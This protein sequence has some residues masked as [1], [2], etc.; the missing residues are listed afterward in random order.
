[1]AGDPLEPYRE[2]VRRH[3]ASFEGMLWRSPEMQVARFRILME[4]VAA[5]LGEDGTGGRSRSVGDVLAGAVVADIGCGMADLRGWLGEGGLG[6]A[7]Y[8]GVDGVEDLVASASAR[9]EREGWSD[10]SL[11]VSDFGRDEDLF[12]RLVLERGARVFVFSGS[13]N[14]FEQ[15]AALEIVG[16]AFAAVGS[17]GDGVRRGV[18]LNFLSS[19]WFGSVASPDD[20]ARRFDP[21]EVVGFGLGL[22]PRVLMRHDYLDGRDATVGLFTS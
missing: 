7:G 9:A 2:A 10:A 21:V 22:T 20:P 1:M 13:L 4:L 3:G 16:R 8:V 19:Q 5:G 12:E 18:V 14:T 11:I 15:E 6:V 17:A